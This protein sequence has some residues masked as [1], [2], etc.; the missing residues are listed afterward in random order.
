MALVVI[1]GASVATAF[2]SRASVTR[3]LID[4]TNVAAQFKTIDN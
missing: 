2:V 4:E 3:G 1:V